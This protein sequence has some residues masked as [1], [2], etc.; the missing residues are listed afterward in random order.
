VC[1]AD[2]EIPIGKLL[3]RGACDRRAGKLHY[4]P[5]EIRIQP[6]AA[7]LLLHAGK[8]ESEAG[9]LSV[10]GGAMHNT[11]LG[12]FVKSGGNSPKCLRCIVLLT[13]ADEV[14]VPFFQ[15]AQAR[16]DAAIISLFAGTIPH[17]ALG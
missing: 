12:G 4:L 2:E 5:Q 8:A 15:G 14:E 13:R 3:R 9:L 17:P 7:I 1:L 6:T 16:L 11:G 10:G